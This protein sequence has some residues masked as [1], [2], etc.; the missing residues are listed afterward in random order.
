MM[1]MSRCR[2]ETFRKIRQK[3]LKNPGWE[4][5]WDAVRENSQ[6]TRL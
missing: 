3:T 1:R 4:I 6:Q 5:R 2:G